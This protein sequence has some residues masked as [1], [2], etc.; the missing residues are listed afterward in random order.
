MDEQNAP[1]NTTAPSYTEIENRVIDKYM[2]KIGPYGFGVYS[3]IKYY[4]G[5]QSADSLPSYTT[6]ARNVGIDRGAV[7]RHIKIL[8]RLKLLSPSLQFKG[9]G[10]S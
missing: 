1:I 5:Q 2:S 10:K 4:L 9:E 6:I 7:I 3:V 8:Q